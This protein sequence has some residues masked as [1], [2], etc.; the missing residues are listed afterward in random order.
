MM[1]EQDSEF[2][3]SEKQALKEQ[4]R[5][6]DHQRWLISWVK[7]LATWTGAILSVIWAGIDGITKLL[8]WIARK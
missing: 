1:T 3:E 4:L 5:E 2:T 6:K 8:D 7:T